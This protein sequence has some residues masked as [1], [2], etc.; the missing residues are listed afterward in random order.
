MSELSFDPMDLTIQDLEDLETHFGLTFSSLNKV[1]AKG[2]FSIDSLDAKT[3]GGI[4]F[5]VKRVSD[6]TFKPAA[7]KAM[8][9]RNLMSEMTA[10][11][12]DTPET[13]KTDPI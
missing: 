10:L 9:L 1:F 2:E 5:M 12:D 3:M 13:A 6:H 8:S 11:A 4:L 7:V